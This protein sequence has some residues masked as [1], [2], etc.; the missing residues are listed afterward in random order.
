MP[1]SGAHRPFTPTRPPTHESPGHHAR[2]PARL[3]PAAVQARQGARALAPRHVGVDHPDAPDDPARHAEQPGVVPAPHEQVRHRPPVAREHR[4][5]RLVERAEGTP[6]RPAVPERVAGVRRAAAVGVEVEVRGQLVAHASARRTPH[7][8]GRLGER[9]RV[10]RRARRE[11][12]ARTGRRRAGHR[13]RARTGQRRAA[14]RCCAGRR[15]SA[16]HRRRAARRPARRCRSAGCVSAGRRRSAGPRRPG[17]GRRAGGDAVAVQVLPHRV[18]LGQGHDLD[19]TVVVRVVV[20]AD[21]LLR[22]RHPERLRRRPPRAAR[23][24]RRHRH[25]RL[26]RGQRR[27]RQHRARHRHRRHLGRRRHGRPDQRVALLVPERG[28]RVHRRRA[29]ADRQHHVRQGPH[30]RWR[31]VPRLVRHR[32]A[33]QRDRPVS[34]LPVRMR[35]RPASRRVVAHGHRLPGRDRGAEG[36]GHRA[37]AHRNGDDLP[38]GAIDTDGEG[39]HG[40]TDVRLQDPGVSERQLGAVHRRPGKD[41]PPAQ[42]RIGGR[43]TRR[44][45]RPANPLAACRHRVQRRLQPGAG[46]TRLL[47]AARQRMHLVTVRGHVEELPRAVELVSPVPGVRYLVG[48][49]RRVELENVR[50]REVVGVDPLPRSAFPSLQPIPEAHAVQRVVLGKR[51]ARGVGQRRQEVGEVDQVVEH[52]PPRPSPRPR[53]ANYQRHARAPVGGHPLVSVDQFI[54]EPRSH[55]S[56]RSVVGREEDQRRVEQLQ[57]R[58]LVVDAAD[59]VIEAPDHLLVMALIRLAAA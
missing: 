59:V 1:P 31:P 14:R 53:P 50:I 36:E 44:H 57:L 7:P 32:L 15:R 51:D 33:E 19:Q 52:P 16:G 9:R 46:R 6:A 42:E 13:R 40:R 5:E 56:R 20:D 55:M 39:T 3:H 25:R 17:P 18:E 2:R 28:R 26:A 22:H 21:V 37:G 35:N 10:G 45:L 34:A 54:L 4:R 58:Q 41:G 49:R 27:H 12:L 11:R 38:L 29:A 48:S 24:G 8:L 30:R 43:D 47:V 23:V